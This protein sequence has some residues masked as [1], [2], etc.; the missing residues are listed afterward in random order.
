MGNK[1]PVIKR[2]TIAEFDISEHF[3]EYGAKEKTFTLWIF[4]VI[5]ITSPVSHEE[6][7]KLLRALVNTWINVKLHQKG[8][9][10]E[11]YKSE[12]HNL[13]HDYIL[14]DWQ[15]HYALEDMAHLYKAYEGR[16]QH[17]ATADFTGNKVSFNGE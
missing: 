15:W 3:H 4:G 9:S 1:P 17:S 2:F 8:I 13:I 7:R 5:Y 14:H 16:P 6:C 12:R 10:Q 11:N